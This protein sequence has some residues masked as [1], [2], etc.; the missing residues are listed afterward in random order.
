MQANKVKVRSKG[1]RQGVTLYVAHPVY[2]IE[3][4]NG[5][6]RPHYN[7]YTRSFFRK[8]FQKQQAEHEKYITLHYWG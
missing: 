1:V 3:R 4:W 8:G 7:P 2:G 5:L 6:E